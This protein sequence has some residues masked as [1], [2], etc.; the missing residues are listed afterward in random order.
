MLSGS[1]WN[2]SAVIRQGK[3]AESLDL[4]SGAGPFRQQLDKMNSTSAADEEKAL[5]DNIENHF[6]SSVSP[7]KTEKIKKLVQTSRD[8]FLK[9][10][11]VR[12][13]ILDELRD[14][15]E[16][17]SIHL[18]VIISDS[19]D[20]QADGGDEIEEEEEEDN[21]DTGTT[22][23]ERQTVIV[24]PVIAPVGGIAASSLKPGMMIYVKI[25]DDDLF[26][27]L[28]AHFDDDSVEPSR[29]T[30]RITLSEVHANKRPELGD[31][32]VKGLSEVGDYDLRFE[33]SG[34]LKVRWEKKDSDHNS[35]A[36]E[37]DEY[38][39]DSDEDGEPKDLTG[40][41]ITFILVL[42]IILAFGLVVSLLG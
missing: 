11:L 15:L 39:T 6:S 26:N 35:G 34:D 8:E 18:E 30:A 32:R 38:Y 1:S 22:G 31:V 10:I 29:K 24:H 20:N 4:K 27:Q 17:S 14:I 21:Q 42:L 40:Y 23:V 37:I 9:N 33:C 3:L 2:S 36:V 5:T 41:L 7:A 25:T 28:K 19:D 16:D 13:I 12:D